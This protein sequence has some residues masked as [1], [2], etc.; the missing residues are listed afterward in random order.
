MQLDNLLDK[1]AISFEDSFM[2]KMLNMF[3]N[4]GK[5]NSSVCTAI[6]RYSTNF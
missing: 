6:Q 1:R 2:Y 5:R 3:K 4:V